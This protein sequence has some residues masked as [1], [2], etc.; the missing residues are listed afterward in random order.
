MLKSLISLLKDI[1]NAVKGVLVMNNH[2]ENFVTTY[3]AINADKFPKEALN[4][5]QQKVSN[6]SEQKELSL[7]TLNLKDPT[8]ALLLSFFFGTFGV[9]RFYIG[10]TILGV[11]KLLTVGGFGIWTIIDWFIIL[12][13]TR[14]QNL[15]K[16][17]T[18]SES[19]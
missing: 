2:T 14:Q 7:N 1:S 8:L 4:S 18:F 5:V 12:K 19:H 11:L 6:L 17:I 15:E 13:T 16:L 3:L 9:D 10:N